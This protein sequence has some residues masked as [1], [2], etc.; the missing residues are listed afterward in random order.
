MKCFAEFC[1]E[2]LERKATTTTRIIINYKKLSPSVCH[3]FTRCHVTFT[4]LGLFAISSQLKSYMMCVREFA[5]FLSNYYLR[6]E[7]DLS[8]V[9][10]AI[11]QK[12]KKDCE[13]S[14]FIADR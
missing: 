8:R 13:P 7:R 11:T 1:H 2:I 4:L 5:R 14:R 10:S 3:A 12:L 9:E 6:D